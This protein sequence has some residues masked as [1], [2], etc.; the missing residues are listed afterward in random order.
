[1]F[2]FAA[3]VVTGMAIS[4]VNNNEPSSDKTPLPYIKIL[5]PYIKNESKDFKSFRVEQVAE[6]LDL[7]DK[8]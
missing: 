4:H 1:M 2:N 6:C 5:F 7:K 8:L 3:S